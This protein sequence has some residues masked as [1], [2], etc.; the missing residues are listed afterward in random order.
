[1]GVLKL[2]LGPMYSGKSTELIRIYNKYSIK[3]KVL[4]INHSSDTRY[5]ENKVIT[6]NNN[7]IYSVSLDNLTQF[8]N[9]IH[10]YQVILIDEG[11]FFNDLYEF[12]KFISDTTE[13]TIYIF[14]LSGDFKRNKFGQIL[15][16]IPIC[17]DIKHL[18]SICN[19]CSDLNE[20]SFTCRIDNSNNKQISVGSTEQ[21]IPVC[22]NCWLKYNT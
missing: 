22:R 20:A 21:Y 7:N 12:C 11:Q 8:K 15:D 9:N 17:D 13:K 2:I 16:L 18:K 14:G 1:M 5:G 6:H 19:N 4:V 3:K 10:E